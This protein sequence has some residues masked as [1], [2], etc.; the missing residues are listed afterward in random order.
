VPLATFGL[1]LG[2]TACP[3][4]SRRIGV[5]AALAREGRIVETLPTEAA[6]TFTL[7]EMS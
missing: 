4:R 1:S 3:E 5:A 2:S 6:H 7:V